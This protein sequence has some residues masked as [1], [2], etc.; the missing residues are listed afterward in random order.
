MTA[1]Q[2][3]KQNNLWRPI[4]WIE[5]VHSLRLANTRRPAIIPGTR[6]LRPNKKDQ[7]I[8]AQIN[9]PHQSFM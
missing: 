5:S 6:S 7:P 8:K 1:N 9:F 4:D 3:E 2:T